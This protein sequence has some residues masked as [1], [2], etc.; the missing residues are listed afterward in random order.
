MQN[1]VR[2]NTEAEIGCDLLVM[3][4]KWLVNTPA[5]DSIH[6]LHHCA[7]TVQSSEIVTEELL[8][9]ATNKGLRAQIIKNGLG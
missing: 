7:R 8:G 5:R 1:R 6:I 4:D 9:P 2:G 3:D